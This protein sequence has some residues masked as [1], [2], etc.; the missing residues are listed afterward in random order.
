MDTVEVVKSGPPWAYGCDECSYGILIEPVQFKEWN[1]P[2]YIERGAGYKQDA[3]LFCDCK[4]G[5]AA[6]KHAAR[7]WDKHGNKVY[8]RQSEA[9]LDTI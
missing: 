1:V 9:L 4:A 6:K 8:E 2:L 3:T 5:E 7:M